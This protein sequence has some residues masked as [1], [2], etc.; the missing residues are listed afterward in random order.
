MVKKDLAQAVARKCPNITTSIVS[1]SV[2]EFFSVIA[3]S[4]QAGRRVEIRGLGSFSI[5]VRKK[6]KAINPKTKLTV[7]VKEKAVPFFKPSQVLSDSL[8]KTEKKEKSS[9]FFHDVF[10]DI[11]RQRD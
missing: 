8:K 4:L 7:E 3:S 9:G 2:N 6:R 1:K 11:T 10:R 5:R